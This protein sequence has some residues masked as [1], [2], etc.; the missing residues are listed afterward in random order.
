MKW[1]YRICFGIIVLFALIG[2]FFISVIFHELSHR[3]DLKN[4]IKDDSQLCFFSFPGNAT[5]VQ[6]ITGDWARGYFLYRYKEDV[7]NQTKD[8]INFYTE[9]K[10]TFIEV[11]V[12]LLLIACVFVEGIRR[13]RYKQSEEF[14]KFFIDWKKSNANI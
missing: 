4:L 2:A 14:Y 7:T 13:I 6:I 9:N 1:F 5:V 3:S 8:N 12:L 11:L 10:A